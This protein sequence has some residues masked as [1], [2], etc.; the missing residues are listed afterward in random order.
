VKISIEGVPAKLA[1]MKFVVAPAH[2]DN[3]KLG[4]RKISLNLG[5]VYV[6]RRDLENLHGRKIGLMNLFSVELGDEVKFSG[7]KIELSD[8]KVQWVSEPN[9]GITVVMPDGERISAIAEPDIAKAKVD[10]VVQL[11]RFGF[12][13]I[14]QVGKDMVLYF[15]HK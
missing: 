11:V 9:V 2:P 15:A 14:D 1:K 7:E 10:D 13:R 4:E 3:A 6:E 5:S 12:C 8:Q